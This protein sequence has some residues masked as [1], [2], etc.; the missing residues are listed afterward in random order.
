LPA[1][2]P[3]TDIAP[4]IVGFS[5]ADGADTRTFG[6]SFVCSFKV[7][8]NGVGNITQ[9]EI[10][11]QRFPF[12]A[13]A[14]HE[15]Y[16]DS[17]VGVIAGIDILATGTAAIPCGPVTA[18]GSASSGAQGS[19]VS[20]QP[21]P[22]DPTTYTYAGGLYTAA[23]APYA[24]GGSVQG[25]L[26]LAHPLPPFMPLT[27]IS[28]AL[29]VQLERQ[30]VDRAAVGALG[31]HD[32]LAVLREQREHA[33][34]RVGYVLPHGLDQHRVDPGDVGLEHGE[35][36]VLLAGE[37][38]VEAA[39]VGAR[40]ASAGRRRWS[41][42]SPSPRRAPSPRGRCG[43]AWPNDASPTTRIFCFRHLQ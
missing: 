1:F 12:N 33:V 30:A 23:T 28:P 5:F 16:S 13:A 27:D 10:R 3:L 6:N 37:E 7:A 18:I 24:I 25:T 8:T 20:S 42:D 39:A 2:L 29:V 22:S 41:T 19:W 38:M 36:H 9:W 26:S 43:R 34:D 15:I 40:R 14:H 31:H 4:A 32:Q 35:Q 11:L 17:R 21:L